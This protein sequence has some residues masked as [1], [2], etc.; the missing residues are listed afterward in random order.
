MKKIFA[1]CLTIALFVSSLCADNFFTTRFFDLTVGA[2]LGLSNNVTSVSNLLVKD[3]VIDLGKISEEVP[4]NGANLAANVNPEIQLNLNL[5]PFKFALQTGIEMQGQFTISKD[6]FDFLGKGNNV[7]EEIKVGLDTDFDAFYFI[8]AAL[9]VKLARFKINFAPSVFLPLLSANGRAATASLLNDEEGNVIL[10]VTSN[11]DIYAPFDFEN[12][13]IM[14]LSADGMG[15]DLSGGIELP[16]N[17]KS[18]VKL[19]TRIPVIP[20][21]INTKTLFSSTIYYATSLETI[22]NSEKNSENV[23]EYSF[24]S[25]LDAELKVSRPLKLNGYIDYALLGGLIKFDGGLGFGLRHPYSENAKFYPE[26]Y[27]AG[28]LNLIDLFRLAISTEYTDQVFIHQVM[29]DF[30]VRVLEL[31]TGVSLQ[32][33]SLEKSLATTGFGAFVYLSLGF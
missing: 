33:S 23:E 30:N 31:K 18:T 4:E 27:L 22:A 32:S 14:G 2:D 20:G 13:K 1:F 12:K 5:G 16:L 26:Y 9:G 15:F 29:L 25:G 8:N 3:L 7:G 10:G 17:R 24:K 19:S 6:L 21:K 11:Y 28:T